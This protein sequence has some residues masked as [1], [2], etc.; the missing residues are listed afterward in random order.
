MTMPDPT[1]GREPTRDPQ[2]LSTS[3]VVDGND[4]AVSGIDDIDCP[5]PGYI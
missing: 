2:H 3:A 5:E 1:R 4:I